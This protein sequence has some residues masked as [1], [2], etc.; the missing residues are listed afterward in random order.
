LGAMFF[1]AWSRAQIKEGL[2]KLALA[3]KQKG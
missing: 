3:L 2:L 1:A